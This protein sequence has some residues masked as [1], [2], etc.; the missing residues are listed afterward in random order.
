[1]DSFS[2]TEHPINSTVESGEISLIGRHILSQFPDMASKKH[3]VLLNHTCVFNSCLISHSIQST[4]KLL[5]HHAVYKY[6]HSVTN[7]AALDTVKLILKI[8]PESAKWY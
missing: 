5:L 7:S 8:A 4:G 2:N 1:M 3:K 6:K